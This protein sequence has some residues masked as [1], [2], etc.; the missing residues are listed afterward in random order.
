MKILITNDDGIFAEGILKLACSLEKIAK[1]FIVAPDRQRSATGHAIT[2]H[3]PIRASK[4]KLLDRNFEAWSVSGTPTDCVKLGIEV[5]LRERPDLIFSGINSGANL[6]TDVLYSGTV[7][8]AI[9]GAILGF[10]SAAVSLADFSELDYDYAAEFSLT[11]AKKMMENKLPPDT[12]LN[13]NVPNCK[14]EEIRGVSITTLGV[15]KYKNSFIERI[16]PRGQAYYWLGGEIVDEDHLEGSDLYCVKN[17]MISI[18]P[19]HFD[20]TKFN[21]IRDLESWNI[22]L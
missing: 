2:M 6:G 15:R 5:L 14:K 7:S 16:D 10:P 13:V 11:L 21:L 18:T 8:A 9:E 3:E 17:K 1:I 22:S 12:L 20:L 4:V 19:I